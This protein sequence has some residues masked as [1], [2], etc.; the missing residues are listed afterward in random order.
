MHYCQIGFRPDDPLKRGFLS[1]W[2]GTGVAQSHPDGLGF[3]VLEEATGAEV[4]RGTPE[5][6]RRADETEDMRV[7]EPRNWNDTDV[8]QADFSQLNMPGTYRLYV[9]GV[10]CSYPFRIGRDVWEKAFLTQMLAFSNQRSGIE[11]G[12]PYN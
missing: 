7:N 12:P 8:L 11:V 9:D 5:M 2:L 10:G 1:V 6:S 3:A 4:Y